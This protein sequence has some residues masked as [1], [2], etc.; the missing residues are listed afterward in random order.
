[1]TT[2]SSLQAVHERMTPLEYAVFEQ[3][4]A[5]I[6]AMNHGVTRLYAETVANGEAIA[7][8]RVD[9][10]ALQTSLHRDVTDLKAAMDLQGDNLR[11]ELGVATVGFRAD[12]TGLREMVGMRLQKVDGQ[13]KAVQADMDQRF[14]TVDQRFD[15]VDQR[16]EN[17]ETQLRDLR[18]DMDAKLDT[19]LSELRR[20][21]G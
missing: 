18:A 9:M 4:P 11:K 15:T 7:G 19:I 2:P 10:A 13:F 21:A 8:L 12:V 20:P 17:V 14:D 3:F 6:D 5:T 16:F 1:M